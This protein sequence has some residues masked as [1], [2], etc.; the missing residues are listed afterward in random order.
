MIYVNANVDTKS[1]ELLDTAA[2]DDMLSDLYPEA[3]LYVTFVARELEM[4]SAIW[5]EQ[6][7][8]FVR[9][10]LPY[11]TIL[12]TENLPLVCV[13]YLLEVLQGQELMDLSEL[14]LRLEKLI[15]KLKQEQVES[16]A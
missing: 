11:E 7:D 4:E 15:E 5:Q 10:V 16:A 6:E 14:Q 8:T 1:F 9:V 13:E 12:E 2:L 3:T